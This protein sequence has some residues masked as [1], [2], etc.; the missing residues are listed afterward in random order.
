MLLKVETEKIFYKIFLSKWS[1]YLY[2][3]KEH[4]EEKMKTSQFQNSSDETDNEGCFRDL[5]KMPH[6]KMFYS[7]S[8]LLSQIT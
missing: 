8:Y 7:N 4:G 1:V 3:E 5:L 2:L 6:D